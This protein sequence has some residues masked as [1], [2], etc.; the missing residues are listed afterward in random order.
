MIR[1]QGV[2]AAVICSLVFCGCQS[3]EDAG[4][5]RAEKARKHF[6]LLSKRKLNQDKLYTLP[7][8]IND[9]LKHNLDLQVE[10]LQA[11]VVK[12]RKTATML[13]MLPQLTYEYNITSRNN[14][15]GSQSIDIK[16]DTQSLQT[17]R[18]SKKVTDTNK[19]E[20]AMSVMDFGIAYMNSIQAQDAVLLAENQEKRVAQN[21][22]YE[23][24]KTYFE[25][26][27]IQSAISETTELIDKCQGI[28]TIFENLK[29]SKNLSQNRILTERRR[30]INLRKSLMYYRRNYETSCVRLRSLMGY[31]PLEKIQVSTDFLYN[32]NI[33]D[34]PDVTK[35]EELALRQRPELSRLDI[36][37]HIN[38]IEIRKS[39]IQMLPNVKLFM[40]WQHSS[41]PFLYH[42]TW[43][44]IGCKATYDL[45]KLPTKIIKTT[46]HYKQSE[47]LEMRTKALSL[48]VMAQVRIAHA[49]LQEA[50]K[51]YDFRTKTCDIYERSLELAKNSYRAGGGNLSKFDIDRSEL[52]TAEKKIQKIRALG[53]CYL[54]YYRLL[55]AVGVRSFDSLTSKKE[56]AANNFQ[57]EK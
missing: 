8:C 22:S 2:I 46:S 31:L 44:E 12:E 45:L 6:E 52:E 23:V 35:L 33:Q 41:N 14:Q 24:A 32:Y 10:K 51:M 21:L 56:V 57:A 43:W 20:L 36:Q 3:T 16:T 26:A 17:S 28:E 55:N 49:N 1:L 29:K 18:S 19:I 15:P 13:R 30:F 11:A 9:A 4:K 25:V 38:T 47:V 40:D 37:S 54:A 7:E 50:R 27:T 48:A 53:N 42:Q 5:R 39:I 34:I